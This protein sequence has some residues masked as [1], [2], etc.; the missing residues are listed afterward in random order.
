MLASMMPIL[1][2]GGNA[3]IYT[4][5]RSMAK[6][7]IRQWLMADLTLYRRILIL[8]QNNL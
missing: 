4:A 1:T 5:I 8:G 2:N 7:Y 6:L 3:L